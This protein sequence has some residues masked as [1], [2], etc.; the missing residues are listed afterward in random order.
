MEEHRRALGVVVHPDYFKEVTDALDLPDGLPYET[1]SI[2]TDTPH[3]FSSASYKI[4]PS[5]VAR[6]VV[7]RDY[8]APE[9]LCEKFNVV[10]PARVYV[11]FIDGFNPLLYFPRKLP[12]SLF[13]N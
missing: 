2:A 11:S 10:Y 3:R 13:S 8:T 6:C 1:M 4:V 5:G 9:E 12:I 7:F